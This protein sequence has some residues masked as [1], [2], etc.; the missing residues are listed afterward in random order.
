MLGH[1]LTLSLGVDDVD[2][3]SV[4]LDTN[5]QDKYTFGEL[6]LP[7]ENLPWYMM[8]N[9]GM[10]SYGVPDFVKYWVMF[11]IPWYFTMV[12]LFQNTMVYHVFY[13]GTSWCNFIRNISSFC[14]TFELQTQGTEFCSLFKTVCI[15]ASVV[16]I[17][18]T[19]KNLIN[20]CGSIDTY[21]GM[22]F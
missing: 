2:E 3:F 7:Y 10:I 13:Q 15:S 20:E 17:V 5:I 18:E 12:Y 1:S 6:H 9:H 22:T 8:V 14:E 4:R 19:L 16:E 11:G 21:L